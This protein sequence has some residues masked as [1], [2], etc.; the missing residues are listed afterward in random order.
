MLKRI[1]K[2]L[3]QSISCPDFLDA[4][5][6]GGVTL[7]LPLQV[8]ACHCLLENQKQEPD[9]PFLPKLGAY[10]THNATYIWIFP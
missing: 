7:Q 4:C 5:L 10:S 8:K 1:K 2:K 9:K 6:K 3:K